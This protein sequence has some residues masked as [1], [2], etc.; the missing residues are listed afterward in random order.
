MAVQ[1]FRWMTEREMDTTIEYTVIE[2]QYGD[3]YK[4]VSADGMNNKKE[5]YGIRVHAKS[6][7]AREILKFFDEHKGVRSFIW[8][9]P[10][11]DLGLYRCINPKPEPQGGDLWLIT[12][13]FIRDYASMGV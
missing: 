5:Q 4:Q 8:Q 6:A 9:P 12:G 11:G 2:T 10:L 7:V 1:R 13:T 3:G